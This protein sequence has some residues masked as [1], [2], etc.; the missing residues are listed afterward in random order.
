ML[1]QGFAVEK[2][3]AQ[4]VR[5]DQRCR[6]SSLSLRACMRTSRHRRGAVNSK[7]SAY[8]DGQQ[9]RPPSESAGSSEASNSTTSALRANA[10][11]NLQVSIDGSNT[12]TEIHAQHMHRHMTTLVMQGSEL[13]TTPHLELQIR[14]R[15]VR[16]RRRGA[17]CR[18]V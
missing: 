5:S 17:S 18:H 1:R 3:S 9:H 2:Y 14:E 11:R 13:I 4:P 10:Q 16:Q 7:A 6:A 8:R 15:S 12:H